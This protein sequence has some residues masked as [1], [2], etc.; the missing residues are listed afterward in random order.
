M[1]SCEIYLRENGTRIA[2]AVVG[3]N[4]ASFMK[5]FRIILA[6]LLCASCGLLAGCGTGSGTANA[7]GTNSAMKMM[8]AAPVTVPNRTDLEVRLI[9]SLGSSI[10]QSGET[11]HATLAD[12]VRVN[13]KV[14][15]PAGAEVTGQVDS[16][17]PSGHLETPA[18]LGI[19]LTTVNVGGKTYDLETSERV[20]RGRSHKKHDAKWIAG[21]AGGGALLGALV[22]GGKGAAIGAGIGGGAGATTAYATG[23]K[24]IYLP[25]ETRLRFIL[26]RPLTLHR[27]G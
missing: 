19:E 14:A 1:K 12:P 4:G 7:A 24:D 22:G 20:W 13:Q 23:K 27:A 16:A 21:L 6:S 25:S 2:L 18:L 26:R 8:Q 5:T 3:K 17:R 15:I 10:S 9:E 11:F